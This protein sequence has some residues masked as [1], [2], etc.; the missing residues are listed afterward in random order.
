M[1]TKTPAV[2]ALLFWLPLSV[3]AATDQ[4]V[5]SE[6]A[7]REECSAYS[8]AGMR[9]CLAR[10][11]EDSEQALK[12]AENAVSASLSRWDED[13]KY[14]GMAKTKLAVNDKDFARYRE[15]RCDFAAS[16]SGGAAG[17]AHEIRRL[18]CVAELN[19]RRAAQLG[20]ALTDLPLKQ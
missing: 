10:K 7:L 11:A 8:Q 12:K 2:F 3:Q 17:N 20:D 1:R 16:L 5:T 18:V 6:H 4:P 19:N 15:S 14:I 13:P 9:D